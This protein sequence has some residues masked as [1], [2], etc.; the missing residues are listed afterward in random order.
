MVNHFDTVIVGGS[1]AGLSAALYLARANRSVLVLDTGAPRNRFAAASHGLFGQD[2]ANPAAMIA[3]M[4]GQVASYPTVTFMDERATGAAHEKDGFT[5]ELAS[6]SAVSGRTILLAH[7]ISDILPTV[8]GI[9]ERWGRT[10][11]H[12][13]YCH[14]YEFSGQRL[15]VLFMSPMS[16]HQATLIPEWGPTTLFLNGAAISQQDRTML[17]KRGVSIEPSGVSQVLGASPEISS[18]ALSDGRRIEVDALYIGPR[19][20]MNSDIAEELGCAVEEAP[21]GPLIAVDEMKCTSVPGVYAA[22]DVTR[23]GHTVIFACNDGA[24]AGL[25]IHRSLV[26]GAVA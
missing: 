6:G 1:F 19:Y 15:G 22:G 26:F 4:R 21:L 16:L 20:R 17:E 12:C 18:V 8:P 9:A 25:A 3:T 2:G 23:A 24:M 13:P 14:G 7:G 10:V 11:I 5:I